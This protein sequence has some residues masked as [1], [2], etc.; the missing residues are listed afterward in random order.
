MPSSRGARTFSPCPGCLPSCTLL[1]FPLPGP[2]TQLHHAHCILRPAPPQLLLCVRPHAA[3]DPVA[4][5]RPAERGAALPVRP[6]RQPHQ[7]NVQQGE[8]ANQ[9]NA[10]QASV[11]APPTSETPAVLGMHRGGRL[12]LCVAPSAAAAFDQCVPATPADGQDA[13]AGDVQPAGRKG[14]V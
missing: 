1:L 13:H 12:A 8:Y 6:V 3:G 10:R 11:W 2:I 4:G 7:R 9:H 14:G 5:L